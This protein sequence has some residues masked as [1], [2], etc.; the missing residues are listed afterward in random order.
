M[1]LL[2]GSRSVS[3]YWNRLRVPHDCIGATHRSNKLGMRSLRFTDS[4]HDRINQ[5]WEGHRFSGRP[6][7]AESD[8]RACQIA[9]E[10]YVAV[11]PLERLNITLDCADRLRYEILG[12]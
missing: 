10:A 9:D 11:H 2:V 1:P 6:A 5:F 4:T 3:R 7:F 8:H 12:G